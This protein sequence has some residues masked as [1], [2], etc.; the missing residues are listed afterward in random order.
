[1]KDCNCKKTACGVGAFPTEPCTCKPD[2][3]T[4]RTVALP[5]NLG[6]DTG[7]YAPK[8]GAYY[9]TVVAYLANGNV[10][11]YDSN[12]VYTL[13]EDGVAVALVTELEKAVKEVELDVAILYVPYEVAA[14][15]QAVEELLQLNPAD[16]P[17]GARIEVK[18]EGAHGTYYYWD[19][20]LNQWMSEGPAVPYYTREKIDAMVEQLN[21]SISVV[22]QN[23][24]ELTSKEAEDVA[25]LNQAI[26]TE[27]KAREDGD[28]NLQTQI[29]AINDSTDVKDVVGT[30]AELEAY[31][32]STLGDNDIIK[33][34]EDESHDG[35]ITYYRYS[36]ADSDF[37]Y[38]GETGPYYTKSE[39]DT[40]LEQKQDVLVSGTNIKTINGE[41]ILGSGNIEIQG[42]GGGGV[43]TITCVRL[44]DK[45]TFTGY[46]TGF[47]EA[48]GYTSS[49]SKVLID[50]SIPGYTHFI[51][52]FLYAF[53]NE[54]YGPTYSKPNL[55]FTIKS[56][57]KLAQWGLVTFSGE[58]LAS[59][60][61]IQVIGS[62]ASLT[63]PSFPIGNTDVLFMNFDLSITGVGD[64]NDYKFTYTLPSVTE[65]IENVPRLKVFAATQQIYIKNVD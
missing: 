5:A 43:G 13:V 1:M 22:R 50:E 41:S 24:E 60:I 11:V 47:R 14:T 62:S 65:A 18:G 35:A 36:K 28:N 49:Q 29:D 26:E 9:N 30:Y 46:D 53:D 57:H 27:T 32:K 55:S 56:P 58:N 42:G 25:N 17:V 48:F 19:T 2:K 38:I 20:G 37:N 3:I 16:Y 51:V 63:P 64:E 59:P 34:L 21:D 44:E 40:K 33:V 4:L 45:I 7:A 23:L 10:Y 12:G 61:D 52:Y 31:D 6:D 15:V 39:T 54:T 8:A